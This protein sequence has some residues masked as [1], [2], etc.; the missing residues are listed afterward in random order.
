VSA[1]RQECGVRLR[2][3]KR[4]VDSRWVALPLCASL[5]AAV[6]LLGQGSAQNPAAPAAAVQNPAG[7][8][9]AVQ[10]PA[11]PAAA[12]QNPAAAPAAAQNPAGPAAAVQNPAG[13][14]AAAQ[15]PSPA[16]QAPAAAPARTKHFSVGIRVRDFPLRSMSV[17]ANGTSLSTT[18]T[19]GP[20]RDWNF[21]TTS[22]SPVWG[23]GPAVEFAAGPKLTVTAEI[24]F[25]RLDYTKVTSIAWGVDDPTTT[26]DER[27][28]MFRNED[29]RA[30]L[31][32]APVM[33]HYRGLRSAGPLSRLYLAAGATVRTVTSIRSST[34][35]TYPD[36]STGTSAAVSAPSRR[37]LL[38][39]VVGVGFRIVD[40]FNMKTT[41]EI[42]YT[43]W[44]GSTFGSDS[45]LSPRNQLEV[46]LGFTF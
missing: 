3:M 22:H 35:T 38:G 32:D 46:G 6:P 2:N 26:A 12:V 11:G 31:F 10:N 25:N 43:R 15:T 4:V 16:E 21:V 39:A 14:T 40:D 9:A 36:T 5:L 28:H 37:N 8:A 42:R 1:G 33:V 23:V 19:P 24:L 17:M 44:A 27:T 45:T 41:P 34:L 20:V 29:T 30:Y 18:T 13:P 7:P